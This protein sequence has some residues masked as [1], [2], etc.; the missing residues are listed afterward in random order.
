MH[1]THSGDTPQPHHTAPMAGGQPISDETADQ[2]A[3]WLTLLMS[4]EATAEERQRWQQWRAAH[5]DHE[6]AWQHI[7]AITGRLKQMEAKAA[8]RTLSPYV[9]PPL[10]ANTPASPSRRKALHMLMW[11]G[12]ACT[13][14]L[15]ASRTQTWQQTMAEHRTGIGEQ[16]SLVLDDGTQITLNTDSAINVR[17]DNQR[18][19]I[20]LVAGEVL[21]VTG[22]ANNRGHDETRPFIVESAEGDVRALGTRFTLRQLDGQTHVAVLESAVQ[23][24]PRDNNTQA[25]ILQAGTQAAFSRRT[26]DDDQPLDEQAT[27]WSRGQIVADNVRLGDF[28]ADLGRYR[29][30]LLRCDPS[31][32][33]LRVSGVFPLHDTD[34]ILATLPTVLPVHVRQRTR[35]WV[36]V[37]ASR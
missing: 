19:L 18:R 14:G 3:E 16:R 5:P 11:G 31:V 2:A 36:T 24:T 10:G 29:P 32:A 30:G 4:G 37:A 12:V 9:T 8:Y 13:S 6:R 33:D 23:I 7:E 34:R 35:Y 20:R 27:A 15:L 28:L 22:H 17:F 1:T 26:L 21:I 25:R